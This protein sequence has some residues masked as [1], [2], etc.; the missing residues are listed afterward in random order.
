MAPHARSY[1]RLRRGDLDSEGED[2][3]SGF[4]RWVLLK[5]AAE[6]WRCWRSDELERRNKDRRLALGRGDAT[7]H[8][9]SDERGRDRRDVRAT[10]VRRDV[11]SVSSVLMLA[12]PSRGGLRVTPDGA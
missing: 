1:N 9:L 6:L 7:P 11:R 4:E 3:R 5:R 10:V 8:V 2:E 12:R